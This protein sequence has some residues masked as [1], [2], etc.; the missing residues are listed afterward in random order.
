MSELEHLM[1]FNTSEDKF[2]LDKYIDSIDKLVFNANTLCHHSSSKAK[3]I[4]V[5][6]SSKNFIIDPLLYSFQLDIKFIKN[7]EN[8]KI[9]DSYVKLAQEYGI[10][11]L[12][13]DEISLTVKDIYSHGVLKLIDDVF[14]FQLNYIDL[15]L[16]EDIKR[17]L[18]FTK[19]YKKPEYLV[20]PSFYIADDNE[21]LLLNK[22]LV[23]QSIKLKEKYNIPM[24]GNIVINKNVLSNHKLINKIIEIFS[25]ADGL[26]FCIDDFDET[27][28]SKNTILDF[29]N[30]IK[31]YRRINE[32]KKIYSLYGGYF[33]QLLS[34]IGLSGVC[35]SVAYGES[36]KINSIGGPPVHKYYLPS[37][38]F[39]MKPENMLKFLTN[40]NINT[41]KDFFTKICNCEVCNQNIFDD[42][43]Y[44]RFFVYLDDLA[45]S[46]L[47]RKNSKNNCR[48]HYLEVKSKEFIDIQT[49]DYTLLV[50]NL[51]ETYNTF[52]DNN[53]L[54][55][56]EFSINYLLN[57]YEVLTLEE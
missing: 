1:R 45:S 26:V 5:D 46:K 48:C 29:I 4:Y 32:S 37:L 30:F 20:I 25:P 24:Y 27:N 42:D 50:N 16:D 22:E 23:E 52:I 7:K 11:H 2:Y 57:W 36:K 28:V 6:F 31:K 54:E 39:R 51:K 38:Y 49:K 35:H 40:M 56:I 10:L 53:Y 33:S 12:I 55:E 8:T 3:S 17:L 43:I 18:T 41:Q 19:K 15:N 44:K 34:N 13:E 21:W 47:L 14:N 9:R